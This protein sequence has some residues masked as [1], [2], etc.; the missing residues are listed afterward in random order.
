M[1]DPERTVFN[2]SYIA[3]ARVERQ[4]TEVSWN[5]VLDFSEQL[6]HD[7]KYF[8]PENKDRID[9]TILSSREFALSYRNSPP[10]S[11]IRALSD[12]EYSAIIENDMQKSVHFTKKLTSRVDDVSLIENHGHQL[13]G[14]VLSSVVIIGERKCAVNSLRHLTKYPLG[15]GSLP[16]IIIGKFDSDVTN[17]DALRAQ[18][19]AHMLFESKEFK[20]LSKLNF[21]P[22]TVIN[23][24]VP[25]N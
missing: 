1:F 19:K 2:K 6:K 17:K 8:I 25:L 10:N 18:D 7:D 11:K 21:D 12:F 5:N 4:L 20:T 14:L 13:L 22:G 23:H 16:Y 9:L 15:W 24:L 3:A